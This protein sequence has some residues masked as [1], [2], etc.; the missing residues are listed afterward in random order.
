[1]KST[2]RSREDLND[3]NGR[4]L[5]IQQRYSRLDPNDVGKVVNGIKGKPGEDDDPRRRQKA[6][7]RPRTLFG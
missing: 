5:R 4:R 6:K 1:M 2:I 3:D 7:R